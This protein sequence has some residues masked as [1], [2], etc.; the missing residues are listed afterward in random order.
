[1]LKEELIPYLLNLHKY[2]FSK[3]DFNL[4]YDERSSVFCSEHGEQKMRMREIRKGIYC[5]QCNILLH[6]TSRE[7]NDSYIKKVNYRF[8]KHNLDWS[9]FE[10]GNRQH[11]KITFKCKIHGNFL[12]TPNVSLNK[13]IDPCVECTKVIQNT[14]DKIK[15]KESFIQKAIL[16][17]KDLYKYHNIKYTTLNNKVYDIYC[18]KHKSYFNINGNSFIH[19]CKVGCPI[20]VTEIF[21]TVKLNSQKYFNE[22]V[23]EVHKDKYDFS[24]AIYKGW[25]QTLEVKCNICNNKFY[26][27]AGNIMRGSNCTYCAELNKEGRWKDEPTKFYILQFK[28]KGLTLYK[29]GITIRDVSTRYRTEGKNINYEVIYLKEYEEGR[30]PF[31]LEQ[32]LRGRLNQYNYKG[33]SPFTSTG[34]S[35]IFTINPTP[36]IQE[37]QSKIKGENI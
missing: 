19:N 6:K 33:E 32:R 29:I 10:Y 8:P 34:T 17:Y 23:L 11:Q 36:Y 16:K 5:K 2:D 7:T 35:E 15:D 21:K 24:K 31:T 4:K 3:Y 22:V 18:N 12:A 25:G 37:I 26:P 13:N 20:C 28:F 14:E 27:L 9:N 30:I 1:M